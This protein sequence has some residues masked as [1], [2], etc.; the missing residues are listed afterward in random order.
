[1]SA[2]KALLQ[3][4]ADA[5]AAR[6][7]ERY[8]AGYFEGVSVDTID[9]NYGLW[10]TEK[11]SQPGCRIDVVPMRIAKTE[12]I[13][14]GLI[15]YEHVVHVGLRRKFDQQDR[16]QCGDLRK[17]LLDRMLLL[18]EQ[19]IELFIPNPEGA[20]P[21]EQAGILPTL[22]DATWIGTDVLATYVYDH[23]KTNG[24]FFGYF[25]MT[26]RVRKKVAT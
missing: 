14:R 24:Q 25:A 1:M 7:V 13:A 6:I 19:L 17:D 26:F 2:A 20:T 9:S 22:P 11:L 4:T 15:N 16:E 23:L 8:Q 18:E 3:K 10:P 21:E 12:L 5:V